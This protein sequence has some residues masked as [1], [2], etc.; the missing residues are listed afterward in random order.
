MAFTWAAF[1]YWFCLMFS[2]GVGLGHWFCSSDSH[3]GQ[4]L[5]SDLPNDIQ[6]GSTWVLILP[7]DLDCFWG[8]RP[9]GDWFYFKFFW[10]L[11]RVFHCLPIRISYGQCLFS[12]LSD[13]FL[14]ISVFSHQFPCG[15]CLFH[16]TSLYFVFFWDVGSHYFVSFSHSLPCI[17]PSSMLAQ[18]GTRFQ[19]FG[20]CYQGYGPAI[21]NSP[22]EEDRSWRACNW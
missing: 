2:H 5:G 21:F 15:Y 22:S 20:I 17:C 8:G 7:H 18:V 3:L 19:L 13:N 6:L 12:N 4:R 16:I 11:S 9:I 14:L 1:G 10:P